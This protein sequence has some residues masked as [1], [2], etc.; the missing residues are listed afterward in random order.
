MMLQK[1]KYYDLIQNLPLFFPTIIRNN[2]IKML[3]KFPVT[4]YLESGFPL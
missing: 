1:K 2:L 4:P 3:D